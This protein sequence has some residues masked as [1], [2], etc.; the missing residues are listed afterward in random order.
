MTKTA[1]VSNKSCRQPTTEFWQ[2]TLKI[3]DRIEVA[4]AARELSIYEYQLYA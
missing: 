2:K 1:S 4:A 3:A